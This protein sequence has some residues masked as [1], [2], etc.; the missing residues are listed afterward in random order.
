MVKRSQPDATKSRPLAGSASRK[1]RR[2]PLKTLLH[3]NVNLYEPSR[4]HPM[5]LI[6][7]KLAIG[8]GVLSLLCCGAGA[9]VWIGLFRS[10]RDA[11]TAMSGDNPARDREELW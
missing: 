10:T 7:L 1:W 5:A 8:L 11:M 6:I 3:Y 2:L 4:R 9:L